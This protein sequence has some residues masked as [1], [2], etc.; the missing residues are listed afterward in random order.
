MDAQVDLTE[1][2]VFNKNSNIRVQVD[3]EPLIGWLT[4]VQSGEVSLEYLRQRSKE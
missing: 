4:S 2:S 3:S 1:R